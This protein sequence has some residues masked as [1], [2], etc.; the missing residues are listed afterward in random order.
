[1]FVLIFRSFALEKIFMHKE[2]ARKKTVEL[3]NFSLVG[4]PQTI[5]KRSANYTALN[6][7]LIMIPSLRQSEFTFNGF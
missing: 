3:A 2:R 1:M 5:I 6:V 7:L 4:I